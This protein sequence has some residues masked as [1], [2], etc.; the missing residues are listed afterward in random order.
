MR[1]VGSDQVTAFR[2]ELQKEVNCKDS[3][4]KLMCANALYVGIRQWQHWEAGTR[5]MPAAFLELLC[6]KFGL[7]DT[8]L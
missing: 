5:L 7:T 4:A 1:R 6:I 8:A 2:K 3:E